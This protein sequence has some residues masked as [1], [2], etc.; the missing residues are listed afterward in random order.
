MP[1]T[2]SARWPALI[3][4]ACLAVAA[5]ALSGCVVVPAY[6]VHPYHYY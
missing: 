2:R 5:V 6:R 3:R 4:F 1:I